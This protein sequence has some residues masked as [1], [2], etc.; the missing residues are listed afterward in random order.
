MEIQPMMS[1]VTPAIFAALS[2]L[3]VTS[4][5]AAT[6]T[7]VLVMAHGG[8]AQWNKAVLES[9]QSLHDGTPV[10]VAFGMADACSVQTAVRK[11]EAD[12][13]QRVVVVRLFVSGESFLE[14]TQKIL[15][16]K[17]GTPEEP[18]GACVVADMGSM[19][20]MDDGA[21]AT[22]QETAHEAP[23]MAGWTVVAPAESHEMQTLSN[24][25]KR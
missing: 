22:A 10:E 2:I 15:G 8:G 3:S 20:H 21:A 1:K 14:E 12:G 9:V 24:L 16:V 6:P 5:Q 11:L 23:A 4:S 19:E 7:G 17:P 13:V 18:R 25:R